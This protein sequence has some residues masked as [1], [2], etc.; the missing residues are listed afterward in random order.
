MKYNHSI[1]NYSG[2]LN[3]KLDLP[4]NELERQVEIES[5][6]E[7]KKNV[8]LNYLKLRRLK[9]LAQHIRPF[10]KV[11]RKFISSI[12]SK[13][14]AIYFCY[15]PNGKLNG[16]HKYTLTQL[17]QQGFS[18]LVVCACP[19]FN[20]APQ[21]KDYNIDGL[22]LKEL[23]GY[24]FS[25]YTAGLSYLA[26]QDRDYDVV[27][28]NDSILGPFGNLNTLFRSSPWQL[29]GCLNYDVIENHIIGFCFSFKNFNKKTLQ[30]LSS[31]FTA[32]ISYNSQ[33]PVCLLQETRLAAVASKKMT[34]GS[35]LC[36]PDGIKAH[37]YLMGN[38]VGL[39][40]IGFPFIKR[41]IFEKRAHLFLNQDYY[42]S[43]LEEL[44]HPTIFL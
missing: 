35:I 6:V 8:N 31:I 44:G 4:G 20:N 16:I 32:K 7:F 39:L 40:D 23:K 37:N 42:L 33:G 24:D 36:P 5:W 21:F 43:I 34:V 26:D 3:I 30:S 17:K 38:P 22:V 13:S 9:V 1:N 18:I 29:T 28:L 41:S 19:D 25:G 14:W 2:Q 11:K 12:N 10:P 27:V 15:L